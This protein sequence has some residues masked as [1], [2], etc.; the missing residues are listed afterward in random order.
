MAKQP[1]STKV[2]ALCRY[3]LAQLSSCPEILAEKWHNTPDFLSGAFR[4]Y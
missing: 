1:F 2:R 4:K 3:L